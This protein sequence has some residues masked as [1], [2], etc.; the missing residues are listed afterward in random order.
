MRRP[1][2]DPCA[3]SVRSGAG[4][5]WRRRVLASAG[6]ADAGVPP[7]LVIPAISAPS[8]PVISAK[9]GSKRESRPPGSAGVPPALVIPAI[10][11]P[12]FPVIPAKAGSKR[13]SRRPGNAGVPPAADRRSGAEGPID[14]P[15]GRDARAPRFT[16]GVWF[17]LRRVGELSGQ[18][19][20]HAGPVSAHAVWAGIE[21]DIPFGIPGVE[22]RP[23]LG[24]CRRRVHA[25]DFRVGKVHTERQRGLGCGSAARS[26]L[27]SCRSPSPA[28]T[29]GE[30]RARA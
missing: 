12:S 6:P 22:C 1:R 15:C 23:L 21:R 5:S 29:T 10:S 11:A 18:S 3:G 13:E 20:G 2:R 9:A 30:A 26:G 25:L 4:G 14:C 19:S 8:F 24:G 7:A 27:P 28:S 16:S 17:R